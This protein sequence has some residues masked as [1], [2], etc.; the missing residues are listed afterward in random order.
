VRYLQQ[1]LFAGSFR[2]Q[3]SKGEMPQILEI[4]SLLGW[5]NLQSGHRYRSHVANM[6]LVKSPEA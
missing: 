4:F 2:R 1:G 6:T 3:K 5:R